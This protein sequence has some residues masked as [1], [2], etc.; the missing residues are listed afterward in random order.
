MT[1]QAGTTEVPEQAG[2]P[3]TP[4]GDEQRQA[5]RAHPGL[6]ERVLGGRGTTLRLA[7]LL[8][9]LVAGGALVIA[10]AASWLPALAI[11]V[12]AAVALVAALVTSKLPLRNGPRL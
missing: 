1:V 10:L 6:A 9:A 11:P 4:P 5:G 2:Q 12:A 7:V 3:G 8:L